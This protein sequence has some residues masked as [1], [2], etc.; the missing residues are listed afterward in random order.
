ML[1]GWDETGRR[2]GFDA[3]SVR[4][5]RA[6]V[7]KSWSGVVVQPHGPGTVKVNGKPVEAA[8]RLRNGDRLTLLPTA[9][10]AD[11]RENFLI[12]HEPALL[13]ALDSLLPQQ[14]PP[15]VAPVPNVAAVE[16]N[17]WPRVPR[18]LEPM[19]DAGLGRVSPRQSYF[20][21]FTLGEVVILITGT[22][23]AAVV[24][25]MAMAFL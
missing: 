10:D 7:R 23:V 25:F 11:P 8:L 20:G 18:A 6:R 17:Q 1:I 22:F 4:A 15:P 19:P 9:V 2:V 13:V 16:A 24:V 14:S 21:Y 12:F 3:A 5:P